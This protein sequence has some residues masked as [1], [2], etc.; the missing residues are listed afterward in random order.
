[1]KLTSKSTKTIVL[2]ILPRFAHRILAGVKTVELRKIRPKLI[3]NDLI[4]LY[5]T[6][7]E[8]SLQAILRVSNI[9]SGSPD[10]LWHEANG[11]AGLSH[12]EYTG[13]FNGTKVGCAIYFN[14]VTALPNPLPLTTLRTI[15]PGFQPPQS[16]RYISNNEFIAL[17]RRARISPN[18]FDY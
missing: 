7:P 10:E 5:V 9:K 18:H 15:L 13:Y 12:S 1:M 6:S 14:H 4:F 11:G 17:A 8:Q 3:E 16:H 2:S